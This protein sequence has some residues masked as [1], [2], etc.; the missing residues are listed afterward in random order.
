MK[1]ILQEIHKIEAKIQRIGFTR[2]Y[3]K[4]LPTLDVIPQIEE[5]CR[6][7]K[8]LIL[9]RVVALEDY[10][11]VLGELDK[12]N[13]IADK[14]RKL[15]AHFLEIYIND[16]S[17]LSP[18][19]PTQKQ[20]ADILRETIS[21]FSS[22]LSDAVKKIRQKNEQSKQ[23]LSNFK[24]VLFGKTKAGKSTI[25]EA[26]TKGNG[27]TIGRGG[28]STT[29]EIHDYSWAN[30]KVY[31]TPGSLSVRDKNKDKS[32]IGD[33]ERKAHELLL[34][35]DISIFMFTSDNIEKPEL[36]YLKEI[37]EKGKDVLIL[38]NVK[39]DISNY[40]LFKQRK[41]ERDISAEY[42]KG[43]FDR[44]TK[45][46]PGFSPTILPIHAQAAFFSRGRNPMLDEF[47][48]KN[49][50]RRNELYQLSHFR[51]V[52][53]YL[54]Q[55]ILKRGKTMRAQTIRGKYISI[56]SEFAKKNQGPIDCCLEKVQK[57]YELSR[58]EKKRIEQ[59]IKAF[60][61]RISTDVLME[62]RSRIDT[63]DIAY[64]CIDEKYSKSVIQERWQTALICALSDV[65]EAVIT[66]FLNEIKKDI[67]SL[68]EQIDFIN[69]IF[70]QDTSFEGMEAYS[71]PWKDLLR[72]GS[73]VASLVT[74]AASVGWI[75][76]GGWV[77]GGAAAL[78]AVLLAVASFFKSKETKIRELQEKFDSSLQN[79]VNDLD[80][81]IRNYCAEKIYP[82]ILKK[83]DEIIGTQ[84]TLIEIAQE[85]GK[86]NQLF[87]DNANENEKKLKQRIQE[88]E[89]Q[90]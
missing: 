88:L 41:K 38:L 52:R 82:E 34:D 39:A 36:E 29:L 5:Y 54:V 4:L 46:I 25:R 2:K 20:S 68:W 14:V 57:V 77:V 65:P 11:Y 61:E 78:G 90:S 33:E 75:P 87:F 24:I 47:Y 67:T 19:M 42:Q 53:N 49:S 12:L 23:E 1:E 55:N 60:D 21:S 79:A 37:C 62:A 83:F 8:A 22:Q 7:I 48:Q 27:A 45:E 9:C 71:A 50:V 18:D 10:A 74:F 89:A 15:Q 44:I 43:N 16:S 63:Y 66:P 76:G 31:D 85:F 72:G 84:R 40:A 59:K 51:E 13:G 58:K 80:N 28:Q 86:L 6:F 3:Q 26:L 35:S 56:V 17:W 73:L 32:G 30:L 81:Q 70:E 64:E 69:D